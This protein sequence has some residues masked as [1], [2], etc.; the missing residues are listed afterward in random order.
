MRSK[1]PSGVLVLLINIVI[2]FMI[3]ITKIILV[4]LISN[5]NIVIIILSKITKIILTILVLLISIILIWLIVS[6]IVENIK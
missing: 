1:T 3:R 5:I 4:L 2:I 6:M